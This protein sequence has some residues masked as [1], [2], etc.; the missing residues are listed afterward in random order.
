VSQPRS[1]VAALR[2]CTRPLGS[3]SRVLAVGPWRIALEGLD[4]ALAATLDVRWGGF[5]LAVPDAAPSLSVR[6]VL[7]DS[8]WLPASPG[9]GYR[10]EGELDEGFPVVR[11]Y[12]FLAGPEA[13]GLWRAA[14]VRDGGEPEGRVLDNLARWFT[15][16]CAIESGGL[17]MHGAG[18]AAQGRA[19]IF[20]GKSRSGKSTAVRLSAP[21]ESLGDDFA[22]TWPESGT[23][24]SCA[25]PFDNAEHAPA[26][27]GPARI[28]LARVCRL[29]QAPAPSVQRVAPSAVAAAA[30][31]SLAAFPWALPD[32][33][34]DLAANASDYAGAGPGLV[35]LRF[36]PD[37]D[38]WPLLVRD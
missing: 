22:V 26:A 29:I 8:P 15:A 18:V 27:P 11:S 24:W 35:D 38:F 17:A 7:A 6:C 14:I 16:R 5:C 21:A 28:P 2:A 30:L 13:P 1:V 37:P 12:R 33:L 36:R 23:W 3:A 19:W 4:E 20:A 10:I 9:E 34:D 31:L 25:V 32:L